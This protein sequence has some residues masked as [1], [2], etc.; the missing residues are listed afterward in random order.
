MGYK[1]LNLGFE[2]AQSMMNYTQDTSKAL[3]SIG[4][5]KLP[6]ISNFTDFEPLVADREVS[7]SFISNP[8][9][10]LLCDLIIL[11]GSKRVIEDMAWLRQRGFS[12]ILSSKKTLLVAIC[13]GYEMMF[14]DI[15]D[16]KNI[17]SSSLHVKGFGRIKG[18]IV[19]KK[20]KIVTKKSYSIFDCKIKGY[21][22]HNGRA[23]NIAIKEKNFYGTFVHGLFDNDTFRKKL[24]RKI[25]SEYKGF[26]FKKYKSKSIAD[27]TN[28]INNNIDMHTIE[29]ALLE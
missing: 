20:R 22:I 29:K 26:H 25:N 9:E 8:K 15:Y 14:E 19:F 13:G 23:K 24:F 1:A 7:L 27:F 11:P 4:V 17:E 3:I 21:E 2:D 28:Y 18:E 16:P 6:H 12:S 5:V 10:A